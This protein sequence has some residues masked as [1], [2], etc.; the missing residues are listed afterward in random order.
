MTGF[1]KLRERMLAGP[2]VKAEYDRLDPVCEV[3][4]ALINARHAAGLTRAQLAER[5]GIQQSS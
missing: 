1:D 4:G 5:M 3:A 2:S